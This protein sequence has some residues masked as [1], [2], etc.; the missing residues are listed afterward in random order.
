MKAYFLHK[1]FSGGIKV[2]HLLLAVLD[3]PSKVNPSLANIPILYSLKTQ[4]QRCS[5]GKKWENL[6]AIE[7]KLCYKHPSACSR[8]LAQIKEMLNS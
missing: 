8:L 3:I 4:S 6:P 2:K 7:K 5:G 1:L